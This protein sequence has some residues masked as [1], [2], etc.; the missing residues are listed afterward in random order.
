MQS[1]EMGV[2]LAYSGKSKEAG[3]VKLSEKNS[4]TIVF[5]IVGAQ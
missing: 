1:S 5:Y 3:V 4:T 2:C